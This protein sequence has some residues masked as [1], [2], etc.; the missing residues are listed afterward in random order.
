MHLRIAVIYPSPRRPD[1]AI[2]AYSVAFARALRET[3]EVDACVRTLTGES[4]LLRDSDPFDVAI[5]QYNPYSYGRWGIAPRLVLAW[6]LLKRTRITC[7][8]TVHEAFVTRPSSLKGWVLETVHRLQIFALCAG[9]TQVWSTSRARTEQ[10]RRWA[11]GKAIAE[12]PVGSNLEE[13]VDQDTL[14]KITEVLDARDASLLVATIGK[15][16][17]EHQIGYAIDAVRAMRQSNDSVTF[18]RL[19]PDDGDLPSDIEAVVPGFLPLPELAAYLAAADLV[20]LP[21]SS[22]A[23]TNR[24]TL[25]AA[26]ALGKPVL[27]TH[28]PTTDR[29]LRSGAITSTPVGDREAYVAAALALARNPSERERL[30]AAGQALY[31]QEFAWERLARR[32]LL[33]LA[34]ANQR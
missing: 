27:T 13:G 19:G 32:A 26:L 34:P 29:S 22:G 5:L 4:G 28:S 31:R 7:V 1:D 15:H 6:T 8:I 24:G 25:M 2:H 23:A 14:L 21:Y 33:A 18:L 11:R 12:M 3:G 9:R 17:P 10:L 16:H 20:L 30:G